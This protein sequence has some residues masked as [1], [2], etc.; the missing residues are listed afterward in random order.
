MRCSLGCR[1]QRFPAIGV[2]LLS[3]KMGTPVAGERKQYFLC[4]YHLGQA[5]GGEWNNVL[6]EGWEPFNP[7]EPEVDQ[8]PHPG[9]RKV[10]TDHG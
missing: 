6:L 8:T 7:E 3:G 1:E 10:I 5:R 9:R 4:E 2:A